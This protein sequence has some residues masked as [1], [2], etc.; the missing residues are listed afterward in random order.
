[1]PARYPQAATL[2]VKRRKLRPF[3]YLHSSEGLPSIPSPAA[4]QRISES[5]SSVAVAVFGTGNPRVEEYDGI[6]A[7][8]RLDTSARY[9]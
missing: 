1:M 2:G 7:D 3:V 9:G 5:L 8:E 6:D 4:S